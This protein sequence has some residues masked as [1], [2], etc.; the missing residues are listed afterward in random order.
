MAARRR[1]SPLS[2]ILWVWRVGRAP[3]ALRG[4]VGVGLFL[5][6]YD[7]V[8][9][10]V[11]G[12]RFEPVWWSSLSVRVATYAVLAFGCTW[13][14]L[15]QLRDVESY[16]DTELLRREGQLRSSLARTGQLLRCAEDLSRAVTPDEVATV[17]CADAVAMS[18]VPHA[19]VLSADG[20]QLAARA[21]HRRVRRRD[22]SEDRAP[23]LGRPAAR[24]ASR[25]HRH[26]RRS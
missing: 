19:V 24:S 4:W 16:A 1:W 15:A 25:P 13:S 8:L 20:G 5:S 23:R 26:G 22:A 6:A 9:S 11:S 10:A 2:A 18:G 7:V 3:T 12:A 21:G 17:L 14:V